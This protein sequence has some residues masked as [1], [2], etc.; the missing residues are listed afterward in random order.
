M[1][2]IITKF[3]MYAI[4]GI[5]VLFVIIAGMSYQS[6]GDVELLLNI[7]YVLVF[8]AIAAAVVLPLI[9]SLQNP[10][11]LIRSGIGVGALATLFGIC[12]SSASSEVTP[13]YKNL[14]V[15]MEQ[16]QLSG[17]LIQLTL[18]LV[19]VAVVA[20]VLGELSKSVR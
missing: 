19:I 9:S 13:L 3:G 12:Y 14:G 20:V 1:Y 4:V 6:S 15:S 16:V 8:L 17:G 10:K 2:N 7:S 5:T 11:V 18:I